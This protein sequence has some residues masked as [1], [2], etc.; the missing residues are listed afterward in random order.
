MFIDKDD[1]VL[2]IGGNIGRN[3]LVISSILSESTNLVVLESDPNVSPILKDHAKLNNFNFF[4]EDSALS[5]Y[6][7]IQSGWVTKHGTNEEG[8]YKVKT[9]SYKEFI[10]KY[11]HNFNVLVLD[12]E[13]AFANIL[14]SYPQIL[15]NINKIQLENDFINSDDGDYVHNILK[16]KGFKVIYEAT[17]NDVAWGKFKDKFWQF[18]VKK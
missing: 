16:E 4:V 11:P 18:W 17:S 9:I 2:E 15:N 7:L 13:G 1:V 12:C 14:K 10:S 8:W 3:S 6:P 5:E